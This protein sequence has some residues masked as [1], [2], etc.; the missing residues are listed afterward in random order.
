MP[1]QATDTRALF[2]SLVENEEGEPAEVVY[3]GGV[4]HYAIPDRGFRRHVEARLVDD[5][6]LAYLQEQVDPVRDELVRALLGMLGNDDIFTMAAVDASLRNL[7]DSMRRANP[8]QWAPWL[9]ALGFRI[10]VD[11]HGNVVNL[12]YPA[13]MGPDDD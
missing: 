9:R 11:V 7:G 8:E 2:P 12:V 3:I 1:E 13:S 10:I 4:A 6:V 5:A